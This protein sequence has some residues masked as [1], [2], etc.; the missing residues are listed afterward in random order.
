[1]RDSPSTYL[2]SGATGVV[3][4]VT[5][6]RRV[7]A[8]RALRRGELIAV[9]GGTVLDRAAVA[10]LGSGAGKISLQVDEDMFICSTVDG[11]GD[12]I[13]HS[14]DPNAGIVGQITLVALRDIEAG[15]EICFDYAMTDGSAYDEFDC[16]CASAGCRGRVTGEDWRIREL[17]QRYAGHFSPYLQAR[18][19]RLRRRR[20]NRAPPEASQARRA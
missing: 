17:W 19:L 6:A 7:V 18:I 10:E 16:Q 13:N 2:T 1:M 8:A 9:Y 12:W 15:E 14:C 3:D 4:P 20:A 5:G 11:P